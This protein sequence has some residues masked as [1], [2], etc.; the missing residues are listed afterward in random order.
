MDSFPALTRPAVL[1]HQ[2]SLASD[3]FPASD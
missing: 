1:G 2:E 3:S